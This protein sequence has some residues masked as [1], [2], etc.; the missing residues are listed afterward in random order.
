[1]KTKKTILIL[2]SVLLLCGY[3]CRNKN[4]YADLPEEL[5]E[6]CLNIDKH[7]KRAENYYKRANYY[8]LNKD[9]DKGIADMQTAIKLQPDS[10]KY[11]VML[12]DLYFGK[13]E[14]DLT[15][16]MLLKAISVDEDNN[17][18]RL[19]LAELQFLTR[20]YED[21]GKT[22]D[23]AVQRQPHN[24]KAYL[25]KAFMLKEMQDTVGY[26]RMLQLVIDQDPRE[27]KAYSELGYFYQQKN[28]P[29][30]VS[31]YQN[32]LKVDPNNVELHYNLGKMFQ[33]MNKFEEAEQEY[34]T[35][36]SID[37]T[38]IPSLNNLGYLYLDDNIKKYDEAV[39]LFTQVLQINPQFVYAVCNRG[40][41]YEYLGNYVAARKDYEEALKLSTNF[42]PAI[43]G[44][45]RLDK[46][47][48]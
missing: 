11:Y 31:Y 26:L 12:S 9:M 45:N 40:V 3:G 41:A 10:S 23:E 47:Q 4:Q 29:I 35:A 43:L 27:V 24:P 33:D 15:E 14:T 42:E 20:Q 6:L 1:M 2:L 48:H 36:I 39:T 46:H 30:A 25:T 21:C 44:L 18:A 8:Y 32:G 34:K 7:P 13:H 38:H 5:A 17:E 37:S 19:K 22:I 28:D 16:E